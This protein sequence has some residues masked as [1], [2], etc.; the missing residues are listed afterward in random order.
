MGRW[1]LKKFA[2][3]F[4][5]NVN[6]INK[7]TLYHAGKSRRVHVLVTARWACPKGISD[8]GA[9]ARGDRFE[10]SFSMLR[11]GDY[12]WLIVMIQYDSLIFPSG[13]LS[14]CC[15]YCTF[16]LRNS[17]RAKNIVLSLCRDNSC[18]YKK[19]SPVPL[20]GQLLSLEK[21]S[22]VPLQGQDTEATERRIVR[23]GG[24]R[25]AGTR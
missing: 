8:R 25:E 19:H 6:T 10:V 16:R 15:D 5:I 1:C 11:L 13:A 21:H 9:S 2:N 14:R 12:R 18:P 24:P 7:K 22:P 17:H 23:P 3:I 20:Q 4:V